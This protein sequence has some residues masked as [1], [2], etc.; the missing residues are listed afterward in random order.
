[1]QGNLAKAKLQFKNVLQINPRD[2]RAWYMLGQIEEAEGN[3]PGAYD[4]YAR[5]VEFEPGH[6]EARIRKGI[7]A[8]GNNDPES[9]LVEAQAVLET[10]PRDPAAL[11]LR[12]AVSQ[13]QGNLEEAAT[14]ALAAL[15][16]RPEHREALAVLAGTRMQQ[17]RGAEAEALLEEA[18]QAHP[19]DG[20]LKLT[21]ASVYEELGKTDDV[22][23]VLRNLVEQ[24]PEV[25]SHRALLAKVFAGAGDLDSAEQV[26]RQAI[27]AD[28]SDLERKRALATFLA[29][30]KGVGA[31]ALELQ[32]WIDSSPDDYALRF[33]LAERCRDAKDVERLDEALR[34]I[35]ERDPSGPAGTKAR[36]QLAALALARG[37]P[38]AALTLA[39]ETLARDSQNA[40]ALMVRAAKGLERGDA[41]QAVIDL[42]MLLR[43]DPSSAGALRLLAE[44][45]LAR[46]ER[47]LAQEALQKAIDS[48][49]VDPAA[50]L[51]LAAL[52]EGEGEVSSALGLLERLLAQIPRDAATEAALAQIKLDDADAAALERASD[53]VLKAQ[54]GNP[55]ARYIKGLVLRDRGD[56]EASIE[57]LQSA[58]R[59]DPGSEPLVALV[60]VQIS[61]GRLN[62]ADAQIRRELESHPGNTVAL[63]LLRDLYLAKTKGPVRPRQQPQG[64]PSAWAGDANELA[65]Q[66]LILH[67]GLLYQDAG[68]ISAAIQAYEGM[69][70]RYPET[71]VAANNL[72]M[73][74]VDHRMADPQ[75][76]ARARALSAVLEA[77]SEPAFLATAGWVHYRSGDYERAA[78]LLERAV[79]LE[80]SDP[81]HQYH[82]GMVYLKIGRTDEGKALLS[83]AAASDRPFLG[84][85][86]AHSAL[87]QP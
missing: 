63:E 68:D 34:A 75:S 28:P 36:G 64:R 76:L 17:G 4:A 52:H 40:D 85:Q 78:K 67:E 83:S 48:A 73:L 30:T 82:L 50:Y 54:P 51:R 44:A 49:S 19:D 9:A 58:V 25:F 23:R 8:L 57:Q 71:P 62:E 21:L 47:A 60:R 84:L 5:A 87:G 2:S 10:Q 14:D 41:D 3:G 1:M 80:R 35:I 43:N 55:R 42:R 33:E 45:H 18:V 61:L 37:E 66:R 77:S 38:D 27:A 32:G 20:D 70:A 65:Y 81:E 11:A 29:D 56:L 53:E 79:A 13:H 24:E 74:L 15:S 22:Q 26:L 59:D 7:L 39:Q 46:G 12:A 72:A 86:D 6:Q 16:E 31:A 69:L